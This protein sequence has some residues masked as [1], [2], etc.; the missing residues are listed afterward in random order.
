[1]S[2]EHNTLGYLKGNSGLNP[3]ILSN[4]H[5][6]FVNCILKLFV[7]LFHVIALMMWY[8]GGFSIVILLQRS[9]PLYKAVWLL[10]APVLRGG[11]WSNKHWKGMALPYLLLQTHLWY[12]Q[13]THLIRTH[14]WGGAF[15]TVNSLINQ[16]SQEAWKKLSLS[17]NVNKEG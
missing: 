17:K 15:A 13:S 6:W 12:E 5:L 11:T 14:S 8:S 9:Q 16:K 2:I 7:T 10:H 4:I 3:G 1:M